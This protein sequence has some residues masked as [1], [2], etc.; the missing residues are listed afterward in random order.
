MA[1]AGVL[2]QVVGL[3]NV[4]VLGGAV[5][6]LA[7]LASALVFRAPGKRVAPGGEVETG[8][9]EVGPVGAGGVSSSFGSTCTR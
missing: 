4:F 5:V 2:A 3:R 7:G 9:V 6:V 1:L 8:G